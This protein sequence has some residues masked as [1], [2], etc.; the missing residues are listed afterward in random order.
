MFEE[1]IEKDYEVGRIVS[2]RAGHDKH[3]MYII[4]DVDSK[5]VYLVDGRLK[6]LENPKRKNKRHIKM[7]NRI[8]YHI[9]EK[10]EKGI[11]SD[12][13]IRKAILVLK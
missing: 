6:K 4:I 8:D 5:Y 2:S 7:W 10:K 3:L 11:L 9:S 12:A 13:D 1:R